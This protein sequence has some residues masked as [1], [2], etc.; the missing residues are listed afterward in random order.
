MKITLNAANKIRDALE[1][2]EISIPITVTVRSDNDDVPAQV[3]AARK[4]MHQAI[5]KENSRLG[6]VFG[7][8]NIIH[9][10]NASAGVDRVIASIVTANNAIAL[11][12]KLSDKFNGGV[13]TYGRSTSVQAATLEDFLAN[14]RFADE[15]AKKDIQY[16]QPP[17]KVTL[18]AFIDEDGQKIKEE[19]QNAK[20]ELAGLV[21][22]RNKLNFS[23]IIEIPEDMVKFLREFGLV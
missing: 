7:L 4:L 2:S 11:L 1:K 9:Q 6:M 23:T 14:K 8:R 12:K 17:T 21:D 16:A 20:R 19:L 5:E 22:E 18:R 3:E 15:R 13:D 10:A